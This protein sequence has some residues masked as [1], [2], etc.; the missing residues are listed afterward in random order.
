MERYAVWGLGKS[1]IAAANLLATRGKTVLASD[2]GKA[3]RPAELDA[4]VEFIEGPN[5]PAGAEVV[6][7]SPGLKPSNAAFVGVSVPVVSEIELAWSACATSFVGITGTDGKTT[8]TELTTHIFEEAG[9]HAVAAGNIGLPLSQVADE[10]L[11]VVVAEVSAFQLWTTH[12]FRVEAAAFTNVAA[13]H[14]DYFDSWDEY[15]EAKRTLLRNSTAGDW[16]VFNWDD[17]IVRS[18]AESFEGRRALVSVQGR[19]PV[20]ADQ[21]LWLEDGHLW[22]DAGGAAAKFLS[23]HELE[24]AGIRGLHNIANVLTAAALAVS[25]GV[26]LETIAEATKSFRVGPHRIELVAEIAGVRYFDDSKATNANAALA[27]IRTLSGKLVVIAGGVDKGIEL[28]ELA[29][30]LAQRARKVIL[31]GEIRDRFAA[32]LSAASVASERVVLADSM[33]EAVSVAAASAEQ[34]DNVLLSPACSSFDMF[35]S[36]AH[37]GDVFQE[38]VRSLRGA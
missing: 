13:D 37:R 3:E 33:D 15:V 18:W 16:A 28:E 20:D 35:T 29:G 25:R 7:V 26:G 34:G 23:V 36:Y 6:V 24:N 32:A 21:R 1:G 5:E 4:R 38:C 8:T 9:L 31:I 19:P 14:L 27:G 11:D 12:A 2:P 22:A 30:E 17:G 10:D